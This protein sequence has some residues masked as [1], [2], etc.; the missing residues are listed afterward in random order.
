[1]NL[2]QLENGDESNNWWR[3]NYGGD[4]FYIIPGVK[5]V[6]DI[7]K[8]LALF[9]LVARNYAPETDCAA[10]VLQVAE[11]HLEDIEKYEV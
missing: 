7:I 9:S 10:I 11:K 3:D 2:T 5:R 8:S 6:D 1:L 4:I